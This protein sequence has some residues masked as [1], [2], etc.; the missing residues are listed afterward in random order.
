MGGLELVLLIVGLVLERGGQ[1]S[2][3][4]L[5]HLHCDSY[6]VCRISLTQLD[7][8]AFIQQ[9]TMLGKDTVG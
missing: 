7:P 2:S 3:V 9:L 5:F 1:Q 6:W 8:L 4:M